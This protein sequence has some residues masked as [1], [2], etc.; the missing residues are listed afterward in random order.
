[1]NIQNQAFQ[2]LKWFKKHISDTHL[3]QV[4][5]FYFS[6]MSIKLA[7]NHTVNRGFVIESQVGLNLMLL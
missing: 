4:V 3:K 7:P 5:A 1:M 2:I 6:D